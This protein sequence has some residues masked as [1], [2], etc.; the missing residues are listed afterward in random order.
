MTRIRKYRKQWEKEELF[1]YWL[2]KHE[3]QE[4]AWCKICKLS[5]S[6]QKSVL[7]D[8]CTKSTTHQERINDMPAAERPQV[9][10]VENAKNDLEATNQDVQEVPMFQEMA[11]V[12]E[13]PEVQEVLEAQEMPEEQAISEG[14][15]K[16]AAN[17]APSNLI[18]EEY[19]QLIFPG[20]KLD[21]SKGLQAIC[22][23]CDHY[24][25]LDENV[26]SKHW[27][28]TKHLRNACDP[29][30]LERFNKEKAKNELLFAAFF[31]DRNLSFA[32]M[33]ELMPFLKQHVN[34]S[35]IIDEMVLNRK[36]IPDLLINVIA[37]TYREMLRDI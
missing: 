14:F 25:A 31:V 35:V 23:H 33:D 17:A 5:L 15:S 1:S 21:S 20:I 7:K 10:I 30:I 9:T 24:Y 12:N 19:W 22:T 3:T 11:N 8:H 36:K 32:L 16:T 13:I 18:E 4:L 34:D 37:P 28:T 2:E 29:K 6:C 26:L 27:A